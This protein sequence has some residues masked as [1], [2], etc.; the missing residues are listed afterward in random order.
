MYVSTKG[1]MNILQNCNDKNETIKASDFGLSPYRVRAAVEKIVRLLPNMRTDE[2][3]VGGGFILRELIDG[4]WPMSDIDVVAKPSRRL[5]L[6]KGATLTCL[7]DSLF[8]YELEGKKVQMIYRNCCNPQVFLPLYD[9]TVCQVA[10]HMGKFYI[11]KAAL[12]DISK[13]TLTLET[14]V[15]PL[16]IRGSVRIIKYAERGFKPML[17]DEEVDINN[18]QNYLILYTRHP[19]Y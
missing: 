13:R 10:Y 2:W 4:Q 11:S 9:L 16:C 19:L 15:R 1:N 12:L 14:G 5:T 8:E 7:T 18:L 17:D 3:S 6:P